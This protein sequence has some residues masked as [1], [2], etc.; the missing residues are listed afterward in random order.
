MASNS[1]F[2]KNVP[3]GSSS[4]AQGDDDIR[5]FKSFMQAWWEQEHYGTDGSATSAGI[6]KHGAG[7][8]FVGPSSQL[9]NPTADNDGRLFWNT[10]NESLYIGQVSSSSWSAVADAIRLDSNNSWIGTNSFTTNKFAVLGAFSE[11]VSVTSTNPVARGVGAG[12]SITLTFQHSSN[13]TSTDIV[14]SSF[15]YDDAGGAQRL[16]WSSSI[17]QSDGSIILT[18]QAENAASVASIHAGN[19]FR[20]LGFRAN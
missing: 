18:V 9:S 11:V 17:R 1:G 8:A 20:F 10:T 3:S 14:M 13:L 4:I 12:A 5:S 19:T 7:R 15:T 2:S 16:V 6:A